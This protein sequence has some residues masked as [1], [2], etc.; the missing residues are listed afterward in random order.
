MFLPEWRYRTFGHRWPRS[1]LMVG[2]FA[3]AMTMAGVGQAAQADPLADRAFYEAPKEFPAV[4]GRLIKS[5]SFDR[6]LPD[7]A[8]AERILYSTTALDGSIRVASGLVIVPERKMDGALP[9]LL[10]AHGATGVAQAC[11]PSLLDDPLGAGAMPAQQ[12]VIDA[13][14]AL[15]VPDYVGLGTAGPHPFLVGVADARSSLDAVRAA[16][17]LDGLILAKKTVA[18]G[19]SQGGAVALWAGIEATTY[20]PDVP[21]SGIAAMAPASDLPGLA[22]GLDG[23]PIGMLF[24]AFLLEGYD[25]IYPDVAVGDYLSEEA[26]DEFASAVGRCL[27]DPGI[28]LS[29]GALAIGDPLFGRDPTDGP[30]G[31][32]LEENVPS[33]PAGVPTFLGQGG[34]DPLIDVETQTAFVADLCSAGQ[35]IEYRT[36]DG[37]GHLDIVDVGSPMV[38]DLLAWTRD[39]FAGRAPVSGCTTFDR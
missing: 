39:R 35:A 34:D 31:A 15:V 11:A 38:T 27:S 2:A 19:H 9:V 13:G 3:I 20:A 7:H 14:W 5:E 4:P 12:E 22:A 36:Y 32:R 16:R 28:W 37:W 6:G 10:W 23:N 21:L 25:A 30:L 1:M 29:I 33:A 8:R 24:G 17:Q 26:R 18:W